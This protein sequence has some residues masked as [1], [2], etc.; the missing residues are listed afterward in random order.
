MLIHLFSSSVASSSFVFLLLVFIVYIDIYSFSFDGALLTFNTYM[1][2]YEQ[3]NENKN[4]E[5]NKKKIS[6]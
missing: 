1:T 2:E 6:S 3:T 4:A 5:R